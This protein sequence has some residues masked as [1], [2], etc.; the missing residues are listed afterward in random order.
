ME[1]EPKA[2]TEEIE[3][4]AAIARV[5]GEM[6]D[7]AAR[8]RVLNWAC[9]RFAAGRA[10]VEQSEADSHA[11]DPDLAVDSLGEMFASRTEQAID[12]DLSEFAAP[13]AFAPPESSAATPPPDMSKLP[14]ETV[15]R[16]FAAD[17]QRFADEWN[18]AAA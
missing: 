14:I 11:V 10:V 15:L 3:A 9:E 1:A 4:M 18:G 17:F 7:P 2:L 5:L 13:D 8:Q 12:D 16:S 6:T